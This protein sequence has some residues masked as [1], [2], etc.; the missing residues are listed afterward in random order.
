MSR[1]VMAKQGSEM[2]CTANG[3]AKVMLSKLELG[4]ATA[5]RCAAKQRIVKHC[6]ATVWHRIAQQRYGIAMQISVKAISQNKN[7]LY[8]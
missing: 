4:K 3:T 6:K 2:L 1:K 8:K 7:T 5:L